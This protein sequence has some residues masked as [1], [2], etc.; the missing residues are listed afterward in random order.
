MS[1]REETLPVHASIATLRNCAELSALAS[2]TD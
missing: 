2:Y 1:K